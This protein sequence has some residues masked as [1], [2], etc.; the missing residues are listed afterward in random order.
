MTPP[1]S[2]ART[3]AVARALSDPNFTNATLA[4]ATIALTALDD[5]RTTTLT[6]GAIPS[7]VNAAVN[8]LTTA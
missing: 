2:P 1:T 3:L 4:G 7:C 6:L 8:L 5:L